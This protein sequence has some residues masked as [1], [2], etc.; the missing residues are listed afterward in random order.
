[1]DIVEAARGGRVRRIPIWIMR[2]AGRYLPEY[3]ALRER[4]S[5]VQLNKVPSIAAEVTLQPVRR[6]DLDAAI[7]FSD[8]LWVLECFGFQVAF[9]PGPR[10]MPALEPRDAL[11]RLSNAKPQLG[12][13]EFVFE[14]VRRSRENLDPGKALFGFSGAPFTILTY[15]VQGGG[16]Y[17]LASVKRLAFMEPGLVCEALD[18]L[19][20]ILG[21]YLQGQVE[22][23]ADIVQV[24]DTWA[25]MLAAEDLET[26]AIAPAA[27]VVQ[28]VRKETGCPVV[29]Y[30]GFCGARLRV[31]ASTGSDVVSVDHRTPMYQAVQTL[32]REV[33]VQGN[34]DPA[35]LLGPPE[36]VC[37]RA[38][39]IV[40]QVKRSRAR[41]FIF[42][43]GHGIHKDTS[44]ENVQL[45][46]ETVHSMEP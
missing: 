8:I 18:R 2:Q 42:N 31:V 7:V 40:R 32:G 28:T 41:G 9:D 12:R 30:P 39:G 22:A 19:A 16:S 3:K 45:L 43:L 4:Y 38:R 1:M 5:F 27:K 20:C 33:S 23:G 37:E 29:Y 26:L 15:L 11:R 14:A 44:L 35:V 36:L 24:F 10:I 46:V 17:D 25:G 6:F 34:L 13:L 21:E